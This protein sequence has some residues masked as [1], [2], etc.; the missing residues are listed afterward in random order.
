[1]VTEPAG[2]FITPGRTRYGDI[3]TEDGAGREMNPFAFN[4][5]I[6]ERLWGLPANYWE[7]T[8][9]SRLRRSECLPEL[10]G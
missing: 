7:V 1:M 9:Q 2:D 10:V 5:S 8:A 6:F 3:M 4:G